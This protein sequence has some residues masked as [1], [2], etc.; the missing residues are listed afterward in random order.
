MKKII[1]FIAVVV[2]LGGGAW[3]Y[4][5][6]QT[7]SSST[8]SGQAAPYTVPALTQSYTNAAY[9]FSLKMPADFTASDVPADPDGTPETI[10]LQDTNGNGIQIA[11]SP[12]DEDT[13]G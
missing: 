1:L 4:F 5:S 13:T 7:S 6:R 8:G 2:V 12:F 3:W 11:I 9:K 10:L